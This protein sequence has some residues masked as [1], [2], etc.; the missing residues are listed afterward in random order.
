MALLDE[1]ARLGVVGEVGGDGDDLAAG[2]LGDFGCRGFESVLTARADRDIDAFLRK[3]ERD[4][5]A[6]AF[7]AAGDEGGLV[8]KFQVHVQFP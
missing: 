3:Q 8:R 5:L 4:A 7:A 6:D 1:I 2:C